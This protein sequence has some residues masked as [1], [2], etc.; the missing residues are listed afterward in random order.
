MHCLL[1][2]HFRLL[3][4][5]QNCNQYSIYFFPNLIMNQFVLFIYFIF[6]S[7][8]TPSQGEWDAIA[9]YLNIP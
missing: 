7:L 8:T 1:N 5:I 2:K 3:I 9:Q 6:F 4:F